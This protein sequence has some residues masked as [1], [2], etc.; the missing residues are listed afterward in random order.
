[1]QEEVLGMRARGFPASRIAAQVGL[2]IRSVQRIARATA[3]HEAGHLA[4]GALFDQ[5]PDWATLVPDPKTHILA[6]VTRMDGDLT[7]KKGLR[8]EIINY[9][10]GQCAEL[11]AGGSSR[12]AKLGASIDDHMARNCINLLL[13]EGA[14]DEQISSI[15]K[16]M[17][18]ITD[19]FVVEH[20]SFIERLA[21]ELLERTT[22]VW[23]E[24]NGL[25]GIYQG[26]S[27]EK[28]LARLREAL[29]SLRDDCKLMGKN[30]VYKGPSSKFGRDVI[31]TWACE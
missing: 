29:A 5:K 27:T 16:E 2:S 30:A 7:S 20:W 10:A 8:R 6:E 25:L 13:G 24:I 14:T 28:E 17:R 12:R 31:S 18:T 21:K 19:S 23:E 9:Y 15:D 22:M 3:Y 4:A 1:M 26:K 11:R